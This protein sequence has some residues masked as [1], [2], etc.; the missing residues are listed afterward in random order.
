MHTQQDLLAQQA[1][2]SW[3]AQIKSANKVLEALTDEQLQNEVAPRKNTGI[4]LLGHLVAVHDA[5]L[6]LLDMGAAL[7]S[8]LVATFIK[9][10]DKAGLEF[11][12][13]AVLRLY[14]NE[15]NNA[16]EDQFNNM[17]AEDWLQKHTSVSAEDFEKEPHRNKMGVL[18]SRTGHL[19]YHIGQIALLK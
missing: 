5:M 3:Y 13:V 8:E 15:V 11:P 6:P 16:L 2:N 18:L 19:S 9:S 7:H 12:S 14:W 10:P 1:V 4:Y 17:T